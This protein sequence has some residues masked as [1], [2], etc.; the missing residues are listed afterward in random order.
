MCLHLDHFNKCT[1]LNLFCIL[2]NEL[3]IPERVDLG[4]G[5]EKV[6]VKMASKTVV[7]VKISCKVTAMREASGP[8]LVERGKRART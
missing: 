2:G 7:R 6:K 4:P 3:F 5:K 1:F 8:G